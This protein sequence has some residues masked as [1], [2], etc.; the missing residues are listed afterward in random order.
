MIK[1]TR[2]QT[3]GVWGVGFI[4]IMTIPAA[5]QN[6]LVNPGFESNGGSLASWSY[7]LAEW[8][9]DAF[10]GSFWRYG[11]GDVFSAHWR[12]RTASSRHAARLAESRVSFAICSQSAA[13]L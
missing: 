7:I 6:L 5:G 4:G 3:V 10:P 11:T 9:R 13:C 2:L 12:N 8:S 1:A